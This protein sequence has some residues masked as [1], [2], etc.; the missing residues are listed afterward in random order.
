MTIRSKIAL[1]FTLTV[2]A[3]LFIFSIGIYVISENYR[4]K[5]FYESL[6][7]RAITTSRLLIKEKEIDK[8]L[9]KII[10][11]N[12]L[13]SLYAVEVLVFNDSNQV[14]YSNYEADTIYYSPDLLNRVRKNGYLEQEI[15][16]F[17]VVGTMFSDTLSSNY[18]ILA[19]A[20]DKYGKEKLENIKQTMYWGFFSSI[21]L[22]IISS[23][24]FAGQ[25]LKPIRKLTN[26]ISDINF[27][28]LKQK[29]K[30]KKSKDEIGLL[31]SN[32]NKMLERLEKS[33][34]LQKSFVSNASHEL[35]TPLAVLKSEIQIALEKN[36]SEKEYKDT[37]AR[38]L[39]D[40]HRL[41]KLTNGLLTLAKAE[42][43]EIELKKVRLRIDSILFKAMDELLLQFP[44]YQ[45]TLDFEEVPEDEEWLF[46]SGDDQLLLTMFVNL[47][48]NSCKYSGDK[49]ASVWISANK[50][51]CIVKIIDKGI[52]I[53]AD[54]K[55]KIFEPFYRSKKAKM[56]KGYGIGLSICKRIVQ[57]HKGRI[58]LES[59]LGR[60]STFKV[61]IPHITA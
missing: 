38:L 55:D 28:N 32:F 31:T 54:E 6:R 3:I 11:R 22:T 47:L 45:I 57:L 25:A 37:L 61:V 49:T 16:M 20:D 7:D 15:G 24:L 53:P 39:E 48:E 30:G 43:H 9:L 60:G 26:E 23:F 27:S 17:Q 58:I 8:K 12:T 36:R 19:K 10:D 29:L 5:E 59:E 46:I 1:L 50:S 2:A 51:N 13:S 35:R 34:E 21:L 14:A 44:T 42:N 56:Q 4:Q 33:F 52:G 40:T 41:I 18:V